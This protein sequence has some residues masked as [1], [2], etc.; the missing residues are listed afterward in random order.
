[1]ESSDIAAV[2]EKLLRDR[3]W[4]D[5]LAI[6]D[7]G[8]ALQIVGKYAGRSGEFGRLSAVIPHDE[9]DAN[10]E[11]VPVLAD[12]GQVTLYR[13]QVSGVRL[14]SGCILDSMGSK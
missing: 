14:H 10:D 7:Q 9:S 2:F 8:P 6:W 5:R 1:M 12:N 13:D 11:L 4:L 3:P